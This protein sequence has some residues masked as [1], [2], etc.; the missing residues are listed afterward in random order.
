MELAGSPCACFQRLINTNKSVIATLRLLVLK[1][2]IDLIWES[3]LYTLECQDVPHLTLYAY[4]VS[5]IHTHEMLT[6]IQVK[7]IYASH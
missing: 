2:S 1:F 7:H 3:F 4:T 6:C 5:Y